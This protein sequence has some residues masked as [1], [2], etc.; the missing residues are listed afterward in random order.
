MRVLEINAIFGNP[1]AAP[2]V[3]G[4]MVAAAEGERFS[5]RKGAVP[6]SEDRDG[7][8]RPGARAREVTK[9]RFGLDRIR[10]HRDRLMEE[11]TCASR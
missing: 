11:E 5:R 8:Y 3:D 9:E 6:I 4:P 7:A 10:T 2:V 1:T